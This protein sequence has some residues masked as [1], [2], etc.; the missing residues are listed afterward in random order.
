MPVDAGAAFIQALS[1]A[2]V[3]GLEG[4]LPC[5]AA[6][7][8]SVSTATAQKP[9]SANFAFHETRLLLLF[10]A[11]TAQT[12]SGSSGQISTRWRGRALPTLPFPVY[13]MRR[14]TAPQS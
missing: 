9:S 12:E 1:C 8:A 13:R 14:S 3:G 6:R 5:A 10:I 11:C 4:A 7:A 2:E